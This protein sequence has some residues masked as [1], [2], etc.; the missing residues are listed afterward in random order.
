MT[1]ETL[2]HFLPFSVTNLLACY[3]N[4]TTEVDLGE[5][6]WKVSHPPSFLADILVFVVSCYAC[7]RVQQGEN[8]FLRL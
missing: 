2:S 1:A 6:D 3:K 7:Y 5:V 4:A 8:M